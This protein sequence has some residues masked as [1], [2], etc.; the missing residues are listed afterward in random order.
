MKWQFELTDCPSNAHYPVQAFS[1]MD[2]G[3]KRGPFHIKISDLIEALS[4]EPEGQ[5]DAEALKNDESI[6]S[7]ALPF[8]TIRYSSNED[9]T[10]ERLT[11]EIPKKQWDIRY[12]EEA[13]PIYIGFPRM[14]VQYLVETY[15]GGSRKVVE[16]RLYAVVDDKNAIKDDTPLFPFPF[17]N[18]G[19]DNGIVCWGQN[20]RFELTDL[21]DLTRLFHSFISAPFNEDHGVRTTLGIP[22]FRKLIEQIQ[23][24]PFDD[25]WLVPSHKTFG[26]LFEN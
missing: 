15:K 3:V 24:L 6:I 12:G 20:A 1:V 8:G 11:M 4:N 18:V 10:R 5:H 13:T 14:V 7:P 23:E 9:K 19:K 16:T 17:P 22:S 21:T 25:E 26:S 2:N